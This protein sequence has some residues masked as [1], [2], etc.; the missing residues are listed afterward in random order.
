MGSAIY[1]PEQVRGVNGVAERGD[2]SA[3]KQWEIQGNDKMHFK[4]DIMTVRFRKY[5][6]TCILIGIYDYDV[7]R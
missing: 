5:I 4:K 3:L 7:S 6:S 1:D 2:F